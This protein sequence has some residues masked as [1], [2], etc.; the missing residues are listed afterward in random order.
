MRQ[1]IMSHY[2]ITKEFSKAGF[3]E[4]ERHR[5]ILRE[6][7]SAVKR[8]KLVTMSGIVGCG[9]TTTLR[10]LQEQLEAEGEILVAKSLSVDKEGVTL[11]ALIVALFCDLS[12]DKDLKIS[13][14]PEKRER[15]LRE[16]IKKRKKPVALFIDEAHGLKRDTLVG[17]KRLM[18]VVNDGDG[19]LSVVLAGHPKLNNELRRPTNE[20]IGNRATLFSLDNVHGANREYI[21]WLLEQCAKAGTEAQRVFDDE[22]VDLLAERLTTPL[23]IVQHLG[24]A[25]EEA[26]QIGGQPVT[27]DVVESVLAKDINELEPKLTR[28]GYGHKALAEILNIGQGDVRKLLR[29]QLPPGRTLD[30]Q[31]QMLKA[32]LPL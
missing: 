8:G 10:R 23:Q 11:A 30:L 9:K 4:T 7:K 3:Y 6:L 24:L 22:A 18:E 12:T 27:T 20:E 29:G 5:Q 15:S 1:E 13:T 19:I 25:L 32:G 28:H 14:R 17:L 16:L 21:H 2:G 31:A 26:F